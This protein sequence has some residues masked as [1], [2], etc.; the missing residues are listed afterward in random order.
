MYVLNDFK[1][2]MC[3]ASV[4]CKARDLCVFY[5]VWLFAQGTNPSVLCG[6]V[7]FILVYMY[8]G[9]WKQMV[10]KCC[11]YFNDMNLA[12]IIVILQ[13]H[14]LIDVILTSQFV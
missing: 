2:E 14:M 7:R 9:R 12:T 3:A 11:W 6:G 4:I 13:F 10:F 8:G 1:N 5:L